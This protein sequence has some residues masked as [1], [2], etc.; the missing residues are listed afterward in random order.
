MRHYILSLAV[1]SLFT[2][3]LFSQNEQ[4]GRW[5]DREVWKVSR[6]KIKGTKKL[7]KRNILPALRLT[8]SLFDQKK[9]SRRTLQKDSTTLYQIYRSHGFLRATITIDTIVHDSSDRRVRIV[10]LV[11][12]GPQTEIDSVDIS[13][14]IEDYESPLKKELQANPGKA[15]SFSIINSDIQRIETWLG[16]RGYLESS[17]DCKIGLNNDSLESS[18]SYTFK[19]GPRIRIDSIYISHPESVKPLVV[20]RELK[21]DREDTL[22]R[23]SIRRSVNDLYSTG[24]FSFVTL[25]YDSLADISP[26]DSSLRI[27][28]IDVRKRHFFT[29]E[30]GLGYYTLGSSYKFWQQFRGSVESSYSNFLGLGIKGLLRGKASFINQ[31]I[32]GGLVIPWIFGLPVDWDGRVLW[33]HDNEKPINFARTRVE[34]KQR[35]EYRPAINSETHIIHRWEK[36]N[37]YESADPDSVEDKTTHSIGWGFSYDSRSDIIDPEKG[38]FTTMDIE[39]AGLGGARGNQFIKGETVSRGYMPVLG[40][41]VLSSALRFGLALPYGA[42]EI[43]PSQERFYLGGPNVMRGFEEKQFGE[44]D[45]VDGK[46]VPIGG[47][48]YFAMNVAELRYPIYRILGGTLFLDAGILKNVQSTSLD[49]TLSSLSFNDLSFNAGAG[50]RVKT[51]LVIIRF[52]VGHQLDKS[53]D[54]KSSYA[55]HLSV[56]NAF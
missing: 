46:L 53:L 31:E 38:V 21:F 50:L 4:A 48:A 55:W 25:N 1:F 56:G 6:L 30:F 41:S 19:S 22:T 28:N 10:F 26:V 49:Q 40:S 23:K 29:A 27:V 18:L 9:Y 17:A 2:A 44:L 39:I 54:D 47:T 37:T 34:L 45:S 5:N 16:N 11:D 13:G 32:E 12:E 8:P 14:N 36:S 15:L 51:P 7:N 3:P 20:E 52:E 42:S 33:G 24:L 35:F 43:V